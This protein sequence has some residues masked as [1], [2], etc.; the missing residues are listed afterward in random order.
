MDGTIAK[1][2]TTLLDWL[3]LDRAAVVG[4]MRFTDL[5]TVGGKL[6]HETHFAPLLRMQGEISGIALEIKTADGGRI[7][8]LVSSV[9]KRGS[10]GEPLLIRT[11]LFDARD[12]RAYE[13]ELLRAPQGGR[14]GC[15]N[16][17]KPTAPGY[18]TPLPCSSSRCC[19]T[20]SRRCPG[21]E[22]AASLPHGLPGPARRGLLRRLPHRRQTLRL[23]PRRR[24]RQGPPGRRRH[25]ADP[26][27]PA[28]RR[29]ARPRPR[30]PR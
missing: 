5:L 24:V 23:L 1:I 16:R 13:E 8:V 12:R 18:R 25:L 17:R 19:P 15:A 22:T 10:T 30:R 21:M 20:P 2:N 26:L 28:R 7:P 11:T 14:G 6:Y 4:R 9:V 29:P 3:G 27:H